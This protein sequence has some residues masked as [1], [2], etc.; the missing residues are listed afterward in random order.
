MAESTLTSIPDPV[1][2]ICGCDPD[3]YWFGFLG[4]WP[5]GPLQQ[6]LDSPSSSKF[7]NSYGLSKTRQISTDRGSCAIIF[8]MAPQNPA[9]QNEFVRRADQNGSRLMR[10]E[11]RLLTSEDWRTDDRKDVRESIQSL[12]EAHKMWLKA[13]SENVTSLDRYVSPDG[14]LGQMRDSECWWRRE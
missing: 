1:I 8:W 5:S 13:V 10:N 4:R 6:P 9:P 14:R 11:I 3:I 7:R 12:N 2:L